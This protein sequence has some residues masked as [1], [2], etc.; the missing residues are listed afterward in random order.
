MGRFPGVPLCGLAYSTSGD[1]HS[2]APVCRLNPQHRFSVL[3]IPGVLHF[4]GIGRTPLP[5]DGQEIAAIQTPVRSSLWVEPSSY[6]D[7]GQR[8][9]ID[10]GPLAGLEG[11]FLEAPKPL[12]I[13]V[14]VT[15]LKRSVAVTIERPEVTPLDLNGRPITLLRRI[16]APTSQLDGAADLSDRRDRGLGY[17]MLPLR[18][19]KVEILFCT[20]RSAT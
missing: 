4:V 3:T 1:A 11:I 10:E 20:F 6:L 9:R 19:P 14:S 15:L 12:R 13:V 18:K 2:G 17:I 8:V 5:L 7:V 16:S